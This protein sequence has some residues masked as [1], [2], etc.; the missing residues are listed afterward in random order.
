[1]ICILQNAQSALQM[2]ELQ[3]SILNALFVSSHTHYF[4]IQQ[5]TICLED[6][7][8]TKSLWRKLCI[9]EIAVWKPWQCTEKLYCLAYISVTSHVYYFIL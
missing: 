5:L 3:F 6:F 1:M 7:D 4:K 9:E 8:K 2:L